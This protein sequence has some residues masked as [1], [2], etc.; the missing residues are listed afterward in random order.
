MRLAG[1]RADASF[2]QASAHPA[3]RTAFV[4]DPGEDLS[5]H[6]SLG[7]LEDILGLT[8]AVLLG[9]VTISIR[10]PGQDAD[11]TRPRGIEPAAATPLTDL[12]A[13]IFS[14][15]PLELQRQPA[16]GAGVQLVIEEDDL[17]PLTAQFV[18]HDHLIGI[19][20]C[21][22]VGALDVQPVDR[23]GGHRVS[24]RSKAGRCRVSPE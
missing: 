11:P 9:E 12:D 2:L 13:L 15:H 3:E 10:R 16:L 6:L 22:P 1:A 14:Y 24:Q 18:D 21:Q 19:I 23:S 8:A 20:P 4:P 17:H 7:E 5:H